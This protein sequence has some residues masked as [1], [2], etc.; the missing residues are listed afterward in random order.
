[1]AKTKTKDKDVKPV[2]SAEDIKLNS[3]K[4]SIFY[5]QFLKLYTDE[6][7]VKIADKLLLWA[8]AKLKKKEYVFLTEFALDN[9]IPPQRFSEFARDNTIFANA[10]MII[11]K[12]QE[13]QLTEKGLNKET[14]SP[15]MNIFLLKALHKYI[16]SGNMKL[17]NFDLTNLTTEQLKMLADGETIETVLLKGKQV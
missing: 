12:I 8:K 2:L 7:I 5:N 15:V 16:E 3:Y 6:E 13:F 1:M 11:H 14:G 9:N 4:K 17:Y 10:S